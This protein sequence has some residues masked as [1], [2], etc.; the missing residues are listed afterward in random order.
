MP[1]PANYKFSEW[2]IKSQQDREK[3]KKVYEPYELNTLWDANEHIKV[4][5]PRNVDYPVK[6]A[7]EAAIGNYVTDLKNQAK[8]F[9]YSRPDKLKVFSNIILDLHQ[10]DTT[11][12]KL[13]KQFDIR[14][15][16]TV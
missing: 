4:P 5:R 2:V 11:L 13:Q 15:G 1:L 9:N 3:K 14:D 10:E 16:F 6:M 12:E 8:N 7:T